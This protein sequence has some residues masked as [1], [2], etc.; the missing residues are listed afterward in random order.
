M[1]I[2]L[3]DDVTTTGATLLEARKKLLTSGA[4]HVIAY[5]IAH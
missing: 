5:T 3:I 1:N 2:I 4:L